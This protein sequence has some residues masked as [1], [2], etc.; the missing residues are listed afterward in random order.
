MRLLPGWGLAA[1]AAGKGSWALPVVEK[2]HAVQFA[3]LAFGQYNKAACF[4]SAPII[5]A[6]IIC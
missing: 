4:P 3:P 6:C 2:F 1:E 5:V